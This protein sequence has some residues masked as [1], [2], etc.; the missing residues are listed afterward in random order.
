MI[1][2]H[3]ISEVSLHAIL[4]SFERIKAEFES[5]DMNATEMNKKDWLMN[6]QQTTF[7]QLVLMTVSMQDLQ[8]Y[9]AKILTPSQKLRTPRF[10]L[11]KPHHTFLQWIQNDFKEEPPYDSIEAYSYAIVAFPSIARHTHMCA[12]TS[13]CNV[14]SCIICSCRS[15]L[16]RYYI[17]VFLS[18]YRTKLI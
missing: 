13:C 6:F 5:F 11:D 10:T 15:W 9:T 12:N 18:K 17:I 4:D 7:Y 1:G 3:N 14:Y 16:L 2:F 8:P